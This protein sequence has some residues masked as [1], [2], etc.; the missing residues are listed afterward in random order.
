MI[1]AKVFTSLHLSISC[2]DL[3]P[4]VKGLLQQCATAELLGWLLDCILLYS[5]GEPPCPLC[6]HY[7]HGRSRIGQFY[8]YPLPVPPALCRSLDGYVPGWSC[9][10]W[11]PY[12]LLASEGLS[13]WHQALDAI[14]LVPMPCHEH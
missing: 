13:A 8:S 14:L 2:E 3:P 9:F 11:G 10:L 4:L 1:A 12:L 6:V 7:T 5:F